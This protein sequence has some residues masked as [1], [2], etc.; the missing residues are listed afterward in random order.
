VEKSFTSSR[1]AAASKYACCVGWR[2][3]GAAA[4]CPRSGEVVES[5]EG[6]HQG[7]PFARWAFRCPWRS[8]RLRFGRPGSLLG[9]LA[10]DVAAFLDALEVQAALIGLRLN[11][12]KCEVILLPGVEC[13][14]CLASIPVH[15]S[16][17]DWTLL[18]SPVGSEAS[19][20]ACCRAVADRI[21]ARVVFLPP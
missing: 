2:L 14:P 6:L 15:R 12:R 18:G 7:D 9:G 13:P 10:A 4:V 19:I 5:Q 1:I 21:V 20:D 11:R 8:P 16:A 17:E 3:A